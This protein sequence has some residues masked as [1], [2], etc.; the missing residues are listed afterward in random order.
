MIRA[1]ATGISHGDPLAVMKFFSRSA[2]TRQLG[3]ILSE[4]RGKR[5]LSLKS[6]AKRASVPL[7]L[8]RSLEEGYDDMFL[9]PSYSRIQAVTYVRSLGIDPSGVS[10]LLPPHPMLTRE[11][12]S[13]LASVSLGRKRT[14][15]PPMQLLAPMGRGVF[16]LLMAGLLAGTWGMYRQLSRI[17][18]M[19]WVTTIEKPAKL[20][21]Q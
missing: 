10:E 4:A 9:D 13:Y 21:L 2:P 12:K 18:S 3:P 15:R 5:H 6:A 19:P 14:W 7:E 16:Y 8:A 11:N 20:P 17:R 1:T